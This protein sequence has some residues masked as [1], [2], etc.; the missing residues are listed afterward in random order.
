MTDSAKIPGFDF[1]SNFPGS[2]KYTPL[3]ALRNLFV[4]FLQ[5]LFNAA[6]PRSYHWDE[7]PQSTEI[8]IQDEAPTQEEVMMKRPIITITRGPIQFYSF[9]MDDLQ[10]YDAA[11]A[12]K[13]KSITVPGTMSINCCS[14]ASLEA[15][16]LA[17]VV[18]EHVWLLRDLLIRAGMFDTGRQITI[19]SPSPAGSIISDDSGNK[20]YAVVVS[21]PFQFIRTSAFTPLGHRIVQNIEMQFRHKASMHVPVGPPTIGPDQLSVE[22]QPVSPLIPSPDVHGGTA[23]FSTPPTFLSKQ[24]HPL[25]PSREVN[26]RVVRPYRPGLR[27]DNMAPRGPIPIPWP[28]VEESNR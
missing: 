9:G 18:A 28:R 2:F 16:N 15:E 6:P 1:A 27:S 7:D 21:A 24:R 17:W 11:T 14:R 5:G 23:T 19:G 3:E 13:T 8:V 4:G 22:K 26:V 25:D 12:R 20:W 10:A